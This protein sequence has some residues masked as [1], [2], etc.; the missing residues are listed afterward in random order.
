[1]LGNIGHCGKYSFCCELCMILGEIQPP[2]WV[3][4]DIRLN[5][6]SMLSNIGHCWKYSFC[7]E[8]HRI[9]GGGPGILNGD[10]H[11]TSG[12]RHTLWWVA[13]DI[14]RNTASMLSKIGHKELHPLWW[15]TWDI[16]GNTS[17]M[18]SYTHNQGKCSLHGEFNWILRELKPLCRVTHVIR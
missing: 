15:V 4:L 8:L 6:A 5:T 2:W 11:W 9:L 3:T 12:K 14:R 18:M 10:L 17:T 1:M 7:C 13:Q 16:R